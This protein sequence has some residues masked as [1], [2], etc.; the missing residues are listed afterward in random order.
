MQL[1]I[2]ILISHS[3]YARWSSFTINVDKGT[4]TY[5]RTVIGILLK[6]VNMDLEMLKTDFDLNLETSIF[7]IFFYNLRLNVKSAILVG[8]SIFYINQTLN[9]L[10]FFNIY[11]MI[12]KNL[13]KI[14]FEIPRLNLNS[15]SRVQ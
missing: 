10:N 7:Y 13:S 12:K 14:S 4:Q 9:V 5:R 6:M 2:K 15:C 8:N 1:G 11:R 3:Y